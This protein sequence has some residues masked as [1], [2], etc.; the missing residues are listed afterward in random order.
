[1]AGE[2]IIDLTPHLVEVGSGFR[3]DPDQIL[4]GAKGQE[5]TTLAILA[6]KPDGTI[7]VSSTANAGESLVLMEKAKRL[8]VF[9]EE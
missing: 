7:W 6:Q 4:D 8:I 5:F 1:M 3:F 2:K 9:G